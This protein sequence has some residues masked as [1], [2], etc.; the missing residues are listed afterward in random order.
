MKNKLLFFVIFSVTLFA[1]ATTITLLFNTAPD[2]PAIIATFYISALLTIFGLIYSTLNAIQYFRFRSTA[3][4]QSTLFNL[5]LAC[6]VS[7]VLIVYLLMNVYN[8]FN[9]ATALVVL[10]LSVV[11]ELLW[12]R[13]KGI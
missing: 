3:P 11:S 9:V 1:L 13:R 6:I 4:W 10:A 12:R 8:I 7:L 5:R 2:T